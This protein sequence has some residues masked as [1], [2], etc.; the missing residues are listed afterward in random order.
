MGTVTIRVHTEPGRPLTDEESAELREALA[1]AEPIT[2]E[3]LRARLARLA[4]LA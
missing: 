2:P 3:W 1:T 4:R